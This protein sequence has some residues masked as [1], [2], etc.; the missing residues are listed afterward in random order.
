MRADLA[1][2]LGR[3]ADVIEWDVAPLSMANVWSV[4]PVGRR[5]DLL[6]TPHFN[7]PLLS[8]APLA[9]TL[10][11]LLPITAPQLT[12]RGQSLLVRMW[13]RNIRVRARIVFCVSEYTRRE[14]I[15]RG[16]LDAARLLV[17]PLG[18]AREWFSASPAVQDPAVQGDALR[19]TILFVGLLKPHKNVVRLLQAYDRVKALIPHRLVLVARRTGVRN[20]DPEVMPWIQA[21]GDRVELLESLPQAELAARIRSADFVALPSLHEGF[22]LPALEAMAAGT[23]LL[24]AR[25]GALPEV[26]ENAAAYCDPRSVDD[27]ARG[28]LL[29]A[30]D[31]SLRKR[32][33]AAGVA[34]A[35]TFTW[36]RCASTTADAL[37][38][39]L[40]NLGAT[41]LQ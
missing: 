36:E 3:E 5:S 14:A 12:G 29:L 33:A 32:L 28:L 21:L 17:T 23:A 30:S 38:A 40:G 41:P 16:A 6:W 37:A 24:V 10:H 34:R 25:A 20:I 7:V 11:D 2:R 9:V 27:I 4:P 19:P 35:A 39:E 26:C 18:V 22:G 13:L 8:V 15:A 1:S 31:S